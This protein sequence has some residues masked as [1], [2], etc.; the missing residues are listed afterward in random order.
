MVVLVL[1]AELAL[2]F[3]VLVVVG[4]AALLGGAVRVV[5]EKLELEE[6]GLA[7]VGGGLRVVCVIVDM[8]EVNFGVDIGGVI[9]DGCACIYISNVH[10]RL[11]RSHTTASKSAF[12]LTCKPGVCRSPSLN[13]LPGL[14]NS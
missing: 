4:G 5:W 7:V 2:R 14:V 6:E 11:K 3:A 9:L 10:E 12:M 8:G 1:L 13:L